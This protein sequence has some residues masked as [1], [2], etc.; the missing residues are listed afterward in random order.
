M[1]RVSGLGF[2]NLGVQGSGSHVY[3]CSNQFGGS[4]VW[5]KGSSCLVLLQAKKGALFIR[6]GLWGK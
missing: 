1:F 5:A 4:G 3:K 2:G 6:I